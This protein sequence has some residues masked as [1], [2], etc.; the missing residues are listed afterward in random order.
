MKTRLII[1]GL[2]AACAVGAS[3][4]ITGEHAP[5]Q[6]VI[7]FKPGMGVAKQ[8]ANQAMGARILNENRA[9]GTTTIRL[10]TG[11]DTE[12]AMNYY[13]SLTSVEYAE[14]NYIY[15]ALVVPNDPNFN[16]RQW[17]PQRIQMPA[18]W[19][20]HRGD[21]GTVIAII[22]TGVQADHPDLIGKV[23]PG[24]DFVDND[25]D[26]NDLN[27][28]GTHCAGNAAA[29][30]NNGV[31][32]AGIAWDCSILPVR[33]LGAGGGGTLDGIVNGITW[34]AD[35]G[36]HILSLSLGGPSPAQA[37]LDAC[38]Y[39]YQRN[40]TLFAAAG[41]NNSSQRFY[42]AGFDEYV[43]A[44]GS[45]NRDDGKS[46][47]SN[48][49]ADWVDIA[50]PGG[51]GE[52]ADPQKEIYATWIGSGYAA[53]FGTSMACPVAAGVGALVRSVLGPTA[54]NVQVRNIIEST[55]D[56]VGN[57]VSRGRV[58]GRRA[59]EAA[60]QNVQ[61]PIGVPPAT[62]TMVTGSSSIGG[63][64]EIGNSDNIYYVVNSI[65]HGSLGQVSDF[66]A[67][68]QLPS[69]NITQITLN[70]EMAGQLGGTAMIYL[71]DYS[72]GGWTLVRSM[73]MQNFDSTL[74]YRV[75]NF[76]RYVSNRQ[77][78]VRVRGLLPFRRSTVGPRPSPQ[79]FPL[80]V[81]TMNLSVRRL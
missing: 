53:T 63:P 41:N 19:D 49:G 15:R 60:S 57:W 64:N 1:I 34:S 68:F 40:C 67:S 73:P 9:I 24:R 80:R 35:N 75:A 38:R 36:A 51:A 26:A 47:F 23:L 44:V 72:K 58:N 30:T 55:C 54:T 4:A 65:Q 33:V 12:R 78:Q 29:M 69:G 6:L 76:S 77:M 61:P 79:P 2:V 81:D 66:S 8:A 37:L 70:L 3:A 56:P 21:P 32:I 50:A 18:A 46:S 62:L 31:G 7:K 11:T 59:L 42:P 28:H 52:G 43:I 27:G 13:R 16:T 20:I 22:D 14:P 25:N 74:S 45:T 71:W 48:F 17:A 39:A 10:P 5:G